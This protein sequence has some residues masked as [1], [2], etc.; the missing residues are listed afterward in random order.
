MFGL[1]NRRENTRQRGLVI[2]EIED[3]L[4]KALKPAQ[5]HEED[6]E[7][8]CNVDIESIWTLD[9][10][11][12]LSKGLSWDKDG[13]HIK[14]QSEYRKILS[15][16]VWIHWN[17]WDDIKADFLDRNYRSDADLPF[18]TCEGI[19]NNHPRSRQE[20]LRKQYVFIPIV[21]VQENRG[22]ATAQPEYGKLYR[23]PFLKSKKIKSGAQGDVTKELVAAKHLLFTSGNNGPNLEDIWVARKR[24]ERGDMHG[25]GPRDIRAEQDALNAFKEC[26]G[27]HASIMLSLTTFT[28]GSYF[29]II[30]PLADLDLHD[31]LEGNYHDFD[32]RRLHFNPLYLIMEVTSLADALNFLHHRVRVRQKA[33]A[34]AHLDFKPQNILVR[35]EPGYFVGHW[36]ITDFGT[37]KI[38]GP[39]DT[40]S[41][42]AP[43]DFL[44]HFSLTKP[45]RAP[46]PFQAPEVQ[47]GEDRTVG[48]ESDLWS[49]GC[50]LAVVLSFA[51]G[52]PR[53]VSSLGKARFGP[54]EQG[55]DYFYFKENGEYKLKPTLISFLNGLKNEQPQHTWIAEI[56][57]TVYKLLVVPRA[58]RLSASEAQKML[59]RTC[60]D[61]EAS[62]THRCTWT[63]ELQPVDDP[64]LHPVEL[65]T[66]T[67]HQ[68]QPRHRRQHTSQ[69][70]SADPHFRPVFQSFGSSHSSTQ[71]GQSGASTSG[72]S[73][74]HFSPTTSGPISPLES[75]ASSSQGFD[76]SPN[77]DITFAY[78]LVPEKSSKSVACGISTRV[79]FLSSS[80]VRI[81]NL[82]FINIWST[83]RPRKPSEQATNVMV[84]RDIQCAQRGFE[85]DMISLCGNFVVLRAKSTAE[86]KVRRPVLRSDSPSLLSSRAL[87]KP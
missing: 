26:L 85:W 83:S 28:H 37:S 7:F 8:I 75:D 29:N 11:K 46:G 6:L 82:N 38:K 5:P 1:L 84:A 62:L 16:L 42:L 21:L 70:P 56:V 47:P 41:A 67:L 23:L 80:S 73:V 72:G 51:I 68:P 10:V 86:Y 59:D 52:G 61:H 77:A 9:R 4:H 36:L 54:G 31:F 18:D 30:S 27:T 32:S 48:R 57:T 74:L 33:I 40:A 35:W 19:L 12:R 25:P 60:T 58:E 14:A 24:I 79:A 66:W 39:S 44:T 50:L 3:A 63:R 43:G 78:L 55:N 2:R 34:C 69:H 17:D 71:F 15:I 87:S 22:Q 20:F 76:N 64:G 45:Q 81:Q 13:L 53:H 49:L 65:N